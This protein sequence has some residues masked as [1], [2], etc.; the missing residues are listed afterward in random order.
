MKKQTYLRD[1]ILEEM[2]RRQMS[3]REFAKFAGVSHSTV[4]RAVD[5]RNP[6]APG[7]EFILKLSKATHT[8]LETLVSIAY[9]D[10]V[11]DVPEDLSSKLLAKRI[12][13]LPDNIRE[14]VL[15]LVLGHQPNS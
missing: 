3:E 7:I 9:P 10:L 14:A 12:N 15:A 6:A 13:E 11:E 4:N 8:N 2:K 5:E 1:F